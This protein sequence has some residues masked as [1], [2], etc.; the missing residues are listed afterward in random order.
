MTESNAWTKYRIFPYGDVA[1]VLQWDAPIGERLREHIGATAAMLSSHA[2][3]G[4]RELVPAYCTLTLYYDPWRVYRE[5][6]RAARDEREPAPASPYEWVCR[7]VEQAL[8]G[9]TKDERGAA[10]QRT[11]N[12]VVIPVCYGGPCGPDLRETAAYCGLTCEELVEMHQQASYVV[13]MIGFVPGF[14]YMGGLPERLAAP[15][16]D[17]PRQAVPAGSVGIAGNQTGIY[18][19]STPGGWRLIGR[20]PLKLF[21]PDREPPSLLQAGDRVRFKAISEE[22]FAAWTS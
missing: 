4:L 6:R 19:L 2:I 21:Q 13:H 18:P 16:R 10:N 11:E 22:E 3:P 7:K 5:W 12:Q 1:L 14:P 9:L 15:R 17:T 20:T 8:A